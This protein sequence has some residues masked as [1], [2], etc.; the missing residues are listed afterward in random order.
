[1]VLTESGN[2]VPEWKT[3][4]GAKRCSNENALLS[5]IAYASNL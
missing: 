4:E 3:N 1:M 2:N 5:P